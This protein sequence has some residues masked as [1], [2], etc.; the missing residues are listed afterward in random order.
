MPIPSPPVDPRSPEQIIDD[1]SSLVQAYSGWRPRADSAPDAGSALVQIFGAMAAQV[2][3]RVNKVPDNNFLAFLGMLGVSPRPPR[4]ASVPLTFSLAPGAPAG[5]RV[6]RGTLVGATPAPG[7][8]GDVVFETQLDLETTP[9]VLT[10]AFVRQPDGDLYTDATASA[11]GTGMPV[12]LFAGAG[13]M[14]H[15]LYLVADEVLTLPV[16]TVVIVTVTFATTEDASAWQAM[17]V[18]G[19]EVELEDWSYYDTFQA[20]TPL[21]V[22]KASN[23]V[24]ASVVSVVTSIDTNDARK[25]EL[26]FSIT[27][28]LAPSAVNGR[29]T[30]FLRGELQAWP[31]SLPQIQSITMKAA[32]PTSTPIVPP[33]VAFFNTLPIDLGKDFYPLG[34]QPIFSDA[35]YFGGGS[36]LSHALGVVTLR[37]IMSDGYVARKPTDYP[38]LVWEAWNGTAWEKLGQSAWAFDDGGAEKSSFTFTPPTTPQTSPASDGSKALTTSGDVVL[39]LPAIV[40]PRTISGITGYWLRARLVLGGYGAGITLSDDGLTVINDGVRP[41]ILASVSLSCS[42]TPDVAPT[43]FTY[44]DLSFVDRTGVAGFPPFTRCADVDPAIY[45]GFDQAF[46]EQSVALYVTVAPLSF[47]GFT[48]AELQATAAAE[49]T[50]IP[51]E[52]A[53]EHWNGLTWVSLGADDGTRRFAES[54]IVRFRGPGG[55][56]SSVQFGRDLRWIRA[57]LAD[58]GYAVPPRAGRILT[59]TAVAVHA[60]TVTGEVIGSSNLTPRQAF[61]LTQLPVL[62]GQQIQVLEDDWIL[63]SEVAN[64][65]ASG[66][67]DRHY[68]F[69]FA[70]GQV[71]F[72]DGVHGRIPPMGTSNIRAAWYRAGGG[73]TGNRAV[74]TV[75]QLK[76]AVP[77]VDGVTNLEAAG[78]GA[79]AESL[80]HLLDRGPKLLRHR[81]RAVTA[82]DF[83]DLAR[84]A[85]AAVA[86]VKAVT[87]RFDPSNP[88]K[89]K[90]AG[91]VL[92]VLVPEGTEPRPSPGLGLLQEVGAYL[93]ARA[94]PAVRLNL[95]GPRWIEV[96]VS[97]LS[98]VPRAMQRA[99]ALAATLAQALTAF[100]H[101]LTGGFDGRGWQ[102]EQLPRSSDVCRMVASIRGVKAVKSLTLVFKPL[103]RS[104]F[105]Y[106]D[107]I[108]ETTVD[109]SIDGTLICSGTHTVRIVAQ[110]EEKE[111]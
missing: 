76:T 53:W 57:R 92:V 22:W 28:A 84:E 35:V 64:F 31:K 56:P 15:H 81:E 41:P 5:A 49:D 66:P 97:D 61:S 6:P 72:G 65:D 60:T 55:L 90:G 2:S 74:T 33:D 110:E 42:H 52:I 109:A 9:A 37:V 7:D 29:L 50:A 18:A 86:R 101:P 19:G 17:N 62:G 70:T 82:E 102:L 103:D 79:D 104:L 1:T 88:A 93:G 96:W 8:T 99:D 111:V 51:P 25:W 34:Q 44:D 107:D 45:L 87:P 85:S 21:V 36:A 54:G 30:R 46:G 20:P 77:H 3:T 40:A 32:A 27:N 94:A 75:N 43:C 71:S 89:T 68:V 95:S 16:D 48:S 39:T 58:G 11:V 80:T 26:T 13:F 100:F 24:D 98:V 73:S 23:G 105:K 4:A 78:G 108:V 69:D 14:D 63:W 106:P 12:P 10:A 83:E 91:H 47:A 38:T 67:G 59:N